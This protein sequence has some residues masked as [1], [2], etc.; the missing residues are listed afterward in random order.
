MIGKTKSVSGEEGDYFRVSSGSQRR[1]LFTI[2]LLEKAQN[3]EENWCSLEGQTGNRV[4]IIMIIN[5]YLRQKCEAAPGPWRDQYC[6][7]RRRCATRMLRITSSILFNL[8]GQWLAKEALEGVVDFIVVG[9][10][11]RTIRYVD[12]MVHVVKKKN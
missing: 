9:G 2:Y 6:G 11:I 12:D 8:C 4:K 3:A 1:S 10:V 5:L 7:S